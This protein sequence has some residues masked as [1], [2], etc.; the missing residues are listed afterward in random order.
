VDDSGYALM[1]VD[2]RNDGVA[3]KGCYIAFFDGRCD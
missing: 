2:C 3:R 1:V